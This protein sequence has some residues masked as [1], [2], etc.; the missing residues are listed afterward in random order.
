M[1][2][3]AKRLQSIFNPF[4]EEYDRMDLMLDDEEWRQ[5]DYLLWIT[6][7]FFEFTNELSKTKDVTTHHIFKIYNKLF[8]H[9]ELAI[10]QLQRKKATWKKKMLEALQAAQQKLRDYY[11]ETDNIRGDLYAIGTI[12]APENKLQFF[13]TDDW[14]DQ[15]RQRYRQSFKDYLV[16]YQS[17]L[18]N[19]HDSTPSQSST[20]VGS[21]LEMMLKGKRQQAAPRDEVTQY[22]DSGKF[23]L[24]LILNY[25]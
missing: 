16:P 9:L 20:R 1:L 10:S 19:G 11:S 8:E 22:L 13:M 18:A 21:R 2:R 15:W 23:H 7:P 25:Y 3:R 24:S 17:R 5:I 4:C 12:I 14:S 6:Q